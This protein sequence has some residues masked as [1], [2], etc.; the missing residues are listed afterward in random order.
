MVCFVRR[1]IYAIKASSNVCFGRHRIF[2][3]ISILHPVWLGWLSA[4][5]AFTHGNRISQDVTNLRCLFLS[6]R[7][8]LAVRAI[9]AD[10]ATPSFEKHCQ[11]QSQG[12]NSNADVRVLLSCDQSELS[13]DFWTESWDRVHQHIRLPIVSS[14]LPALLLS[15]NWYEHI[16]VF[17][18]KQ[19]R[20]GVLDAN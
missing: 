11:H 4:R 3:C 13:G 2:V 17:F 19:F 9:G 6:K 8:C 1:S 12:K 18:P 7:S 16:C 10:A 5:S 20:C 14:S 15:H